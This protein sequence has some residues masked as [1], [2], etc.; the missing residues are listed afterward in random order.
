MHDNYSIFGKG[1]PPECG[2]DLQ[3]VM[4]DASN[5]HDQEKGCPPECGSD[6]QIAMAIP[7]TVAIRRSLPLFGFDRG[8][9][10]T[11]HK[12]FTVTYKSWP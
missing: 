4:A 12:G 9:G 10:L 11:R 5:S 3:I 6:L 8:R 7:L 2:S 1:Y